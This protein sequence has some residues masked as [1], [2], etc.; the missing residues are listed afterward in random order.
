MQAMMQAL[1]Q[2]M[3]QAL[4]QGPWTGAVDPV[5]RGPIKGVCPLSDLGRPNRI[6]RLELTERLGKEGEAP[7]E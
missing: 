7:T 1:M 6:G 2:A 5:H 3:T 4:T